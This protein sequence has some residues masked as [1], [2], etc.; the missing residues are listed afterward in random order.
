[1]GTI[2]HYG[3][4]PSIW[5][6]LPLVRP[7]AVLGWVRDWVTLMVKI[8]NRHNMTLNA[9][10]PDKRDLQSKDIQKTLSVQR[11]SVFDS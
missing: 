3:L 10:I 5:V 11:S 4:G 7:N 2:G 8:E 1:M 9:A 6:L